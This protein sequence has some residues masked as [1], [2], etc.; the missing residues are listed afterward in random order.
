[1]KK[2]KMKLRD[3]ECYDSYHLKFQSG[4]DDAHIRI[5]WMHILFRGKLFAF[6]H[7]M[8]SLNWPAAGVHVSFIL[9]KY[10]SNS[11]GKWGREKEKR[12]LIY[13]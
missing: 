13:L 6:V 4:I 7:W 1:M 2:K 11:W 12:L 9:H 3:K 8:V 10:A 5:W